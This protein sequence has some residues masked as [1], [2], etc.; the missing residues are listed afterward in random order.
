MD[1]TKLTEKELIR[2]YGACT[3]EMK[4]RGIARTNAITGE[5]GEHMVVEY[6]NNSNDLP[7]LS[8]VDTGVQGYDAYDRKG[9]RYSI[10]SCTNNTTG[11]FSSLNDKGIQIVKNQEFDYVIVCKMNKEFELEAIYQLDWDAFNKHKKWAK[12][13]G[14]WNLT[15]TKKMIADSKIVFINY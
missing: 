11:G 1:L 15:L 2:L 6:Y 8:L 13:I 12:S 4:N 3:K 14:T 5:L 9:K 7:K 10:K